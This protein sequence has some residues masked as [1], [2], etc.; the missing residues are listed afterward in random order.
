MG[1]AMTEA[2]RR[3]AMANAERSLSWVIV[4]L[5][6]AIG[7]VRGWPRALRYP[8]APLFDILVV[9]AAATALWF[10][11]TYQG[12]RL[13]RAA[14]RRSLRSSRH[15]SDS[16]V[17]ALTIGALC[18]IAIL[19][20]KWLL[21]WSITPI[22]LLLTAARS[23]AVAIAVG[24]ASHAL[25]RRNLW[26]GSEDWL[27]RLVCAALCVF[28]LAALARLHS[29]LPPDAAVLLAVGAVGF[30][31][32]AVTSARLPRWLLLA[33][34]AF[35]AAGSHLG[36]LPRPRAAVAGG[37]P[38][39]PNVLLITIDTLRRDHLGLYGYA[40]NTSPCIDALATRSVVFEQAVTPIPL[41]LPAHNSL[42]TGL[43][44]K[45]HGVL[46]NARKTFLAPRVQTL[47]ERLDRMGYDTAAF[48]SSAVLAHRS[49]D[50]DRGF[51]YFDDRRPGVLHLP[52]TALEL[53]EVRALLRLP[54]GEIERSER[55]AE[56]TT[57]AALRWLSTRRQP[58]FAWVH[59][60]DPHSRYSPPEPF[61]RLFSGNYDGPARGVNWY[62]T[63]FETRRR[64]ISSKD[65]LEYMVSQYDGE[66]AYTDHWF[67][68]LVQE[69]AARDLM[70]N[71]VVV[72]T[73]DHGESLTEHDYFF[74][75][76]VC[77]YNT[78]VLIPMIVRLP[79]ERGAGHH[80]AQQVR[81]FDLFP[82]IL[83]LLGEN[84]GEEIDGRSLVPFWEAESLPPGTD[85]YLNIYRPEIAGDKEL[86]GI[87]TADGRKFVQTSAWWGDQLRMKPLSQYF[88]TRADPLELIN[89]AGQR[90]D[91]S[92][93]LLEDVIR[94]NR[95][96]IATAE[97][98]ADLDEEAR[99]LL[100]SLG[101]AGE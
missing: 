78:C 101:Y 84:A 19:I 23:A 10:I 94:W 11:L 77:L 1:E 49:S 34:L 8:L 39:P 33:P 4:L 83:E 42:L 93:R 40:R 35:A 17:V 36:D 22:G 28:P 13:S 81:L 67:G 6:L 45:R 80:V 55:N 56:W 63:D 69:M 47:A 88:D 44:P 12:I 87:Q 65:D 16:L 15:E 2:N 38:H 82:T 26:A 61:N 37:E 62:T 96:D 71:T 18:V 43:Y 91:E 73:A 76:S 66:I 52:E 64:I 54:R 97:H 68:R 7:L 9:S 20:R 60:Y 30:A 25:S 98:A 14:I 74:D 75:H 31:I 99:E 85:C 57:L 50:I 27:F 41:T 21:D 92:G 53:P 79:G 46:D 90:R 48:V 24:L 95:T 51:R 59:Y 5:G 89:L 29:T 3:V 58:F 70:E 72:V 32:L 100:R 86:F